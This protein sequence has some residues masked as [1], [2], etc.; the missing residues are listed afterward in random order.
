MTKL[1]KE[2]LDVINAELKPLYVIACAGSGKTKTAVQRVAKIREDL[3]NSRGYV[4]LLSFSN[5]AVETFKNDYIPLKKNTSIFSNRV[6]IDTL[7]RFLTQYILLPHGHSTMKCTS[8]PFLIEGVEPFLQNEKYKFKALTTDN[9]EYPIQPSLIKNVCF[10]LYKDKWQFVIGT[11][12]NGFHVVING[13]L[14]T[15][16]L[17]AIGAYTHNLG[18]YWAV[19]SLQEQSGLLKVLSR[20]FPYIIVDE[21][22]DLDCLHQDLLN[23]LSRA[24]TVVSLIG[25]PAQAIY[26]FTGANGKFLNSKK[27]EF[28]N[29][30]LPLS[31]NYRS[32][33]SIQNLA[34]L[35]SKRNDRADRNETTNNAGL[36]YSVFKTREHNKLVEKFIIKIKTCDL[37]LSKSAVL[38]RGRGQ[39]RT[40][41]NTPSK[42]GQSSIALLLKATVERD[43]HNRIYEAFKLICSCIVGLL[44]RAPDNTYSLLLN[45]QGDSRYSSARL[46]IWT[47]LKSPELGL[48]S[49]TLDTKSQWHPLLQK[50]I[51]ELIEFVSFTLELS[52]VENIRRKLAKRALP[53]GVLVPIEE[54]SHTTSIRVDTVHQAKGQSLDAVLYFASKAHIEAMLAGIDTEVGRVGYVALT[55]AR[56]LFVLSVIES[57]KKD[58]IPKLEKLGFKP[59]DT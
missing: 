59:L 25:D 8:T 40:L 19:R 16:A 10:R 22:Q 27:T 29:N 54:K 3:K 9:V 50:R 12:Q 55:R 13:K 24:G 34:S 2:Q 38:C 17:G 42:K 48:P 37:E 5:I 26:E 15:E 18:K 6:T 31:K 1:S 30:S 28:P 41:N 11:K 45:P 47:F 4:A 56:D 7:D 33:P 49:G 58:L 57:A 20:R 23:K 51:I 39:L 32:T 43:V 46:K 14:V 21:A 35:L 52:T 44:D 36:F 53:E